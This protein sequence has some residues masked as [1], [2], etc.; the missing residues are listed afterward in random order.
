MSEAEL[1]A[2]MNAARGASETVVEPGWL[3]Q[4]N[5]A[6]CA[7]L[8][9]LW[10]NQDAARW[11]M[12]E[13][14]QAVASGARCERETCRSRSFRLR[15]YQVRV[16]RE[17]ERVAVERMIARRDSAPH[18]Y[19][20]AEATELAR[21]AKLLP[22]A[23]CLVHA[24]FEELC[25][26]GAEARSVAVQGYNRLHTEELTSPLLA[27]TVYLCLGHE[28]F[29]ICDQHCDQTYVGRSGE[30]VCAL[31][32]MV[33][34][35]PESA[36]TFGDGTAR[37]GDVDVGGG[38][39]TGGLGAA[40]TGEDLREERQFGH[41]SATARP[42]RGYGESEVLR[43]RGSL[44][45]RRRGRGHGAVV[46]GAVRS[47]RDRLALA[48]LAAQSS[49]DDN[50]LPAEEQAK[51]F[52]EAARNVANVP[53]GDAPSTPPEGAA[54]QRK[55]RRAKRVKATLSSAVAH[56]KL[57]VPLDVYRFLTDSDC[58]PAATDADTHTAA[59]LAGADAAAVGTHIA[60]RLAGGSQSAWQ[61]EVVG[62]QVLL[63]LSV[64]ATVP[65]GER[66][67]EFNDAFL[68]DMLEEKRMRAARLARF[69]VQEQQPSAAA[70]AYELFG[71]GLL[72]AQYGER[73]CAIFW[74]LFGSEERS[75]IEQSREDAAHE[76]LRIAVEAYSN[77]RKRARQALLAED[78]ARLALSARESGVVFKR[79]VIDHTLWALT[80]THAALLITEFYL[81]MVSF[82]QQY[83]DQFAP[84]VVDAVQTH[85][86]FEH[87]V[88][89]I[90]FFM[91]AGF[92]INGVVVLPPERIVVHEWFP[93]T[94]ALRALGVPEQTMTHLCSTV[95]AYIASARE[96][97]VS[98]RRLEA[99]LIEPEEL[100]ALRLPSADSPPIDDSH[101][102]AERAAQQLV[103][104]FVAKRT[105]RLDALSR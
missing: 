17:Q 102:F 3:A 57:L 101:A 2:D 16:V 12:L 85:F 97:R 55:L 94:A 13:G 67:A 82:V 93:E 20:S 21:R 22:Q 81:N 87:F 74:R 39:E 78:F 5:R 89:V 70:A 24:C 1:W 28:R 47:L 60:A 49:G 99:T 71:T 41:T 15:L 63:T 72:F 45:G 30:S 35:A 18:L 6:I 11:Q 68:R 48:K 88:P 10:L 104:L 100:M 51:Q 98:M 64:R 8:S 19:L 23:A 7:Q 61:A 76:R 96:T 42:R 105:K 92:D 43:E 9:Q 54:R 69:R 77:D 103:R 79:L 50:A 31:S 29:H 37:V 66:S 91:R 26:L 34:M 25:L 80:E 84:D 46:G 40:L 27:T 75:A 83:A 4:F 14:E 33:K 59:R 38:V 52:A 90:L 86:Y 36:F 65:F 58:P 56:T 44:V 73:A 62:E 32:S 53:L 95:R